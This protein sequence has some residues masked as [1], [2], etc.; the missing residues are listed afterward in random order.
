VPGAAVSPVACRQ[1][2]C[3][4]KQTVNLTHA[5]TATLWLA[6]DQ[7]NDSSRPVVE[8]L[9]L[10]VPVQWWV[11]P[12]GDGWNG[13]LTCR[14]SGPEPNCG[15]IDSIG[16]HANV[17]ELVILRDGRFVHPPKAEAITN[18]VGMRAADLNRD[19]YLDVVG[20]INDYRPNYAQGH[21]YWQTFQYRDG[22]LVR[23]GCAP[24]SKDAPLPTRVLTGACPAI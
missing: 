6:V 11:S 4:A 1:W 2:G 18:S 3:R 19:G 20:T 10:G 24:Q 23:T 7:L 14:T 8:L 16:M 13:S 5:D 21:N 17:A 22:Q 9:H 15:L 12:R